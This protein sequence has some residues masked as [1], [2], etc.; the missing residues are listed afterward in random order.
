MNLADPLP[1]S[2]LHAVSGLVF[3]DLQSGS[4]SCQL[5]TLPWATLRYMLALSS[6]L[7]P[8]YIHAIDTSWSLVCMSCLTKMVTLGPRPPGTCATALQGAP[9]HAGNNN[10]LLSTTL[11][12]PIS[13]SILGIVPACRWDDATCC[14]AQKNRVSRCL[15][16]PEGSPRERKI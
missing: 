15:H 12:L 14:V 11:M 5:T 1:L 13:T 9:V 7:W 4:A 3:F 6:P 2:P 16:G 8:A 10:N